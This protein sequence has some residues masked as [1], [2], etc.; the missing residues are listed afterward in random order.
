VS[1]QQPARPNP[2]ALKAEQARLAGFV[3]SINKHRKALDLA[4]EEDFG[5]KL[6]AADW[7]SAFESD[8]PHDANRTIEA[9]G[10]CNRARR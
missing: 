4:I 8:E 10:V 1:D 5:D 6:D 7:R 2:K 3:Q 9:G